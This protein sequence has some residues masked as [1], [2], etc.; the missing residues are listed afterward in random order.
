M[1]IVKA[2]REQAE[3][4]P[5]YKGEDNRIVRQGNDQMWMNPSALFNGHPDRNKHTKASVILQAGVVVENHTNLKPEQAKLKNLLAQKENE[6]MVPPEYVY[7][8]LCTYECTEEDMQD[9]KWEL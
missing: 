2:S 3:L 6:R 4:E 8:A 7:T 5:W 9:N 1:C